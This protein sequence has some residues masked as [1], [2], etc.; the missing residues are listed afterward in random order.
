MS[1]SIERTSE[2]PINAR[3]FPGS[4]G[5]GTARLYQAGADAGEGRA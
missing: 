4:S 5:A 3:A 2:S 1:E